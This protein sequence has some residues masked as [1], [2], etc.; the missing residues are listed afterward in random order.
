MSAGSLLIL[1]QENRPGTTIADLTRAGYESRTSRQGAFLRQ[2][3]KAESRARRTRKLLQNRLEMI[4][5]HDNLGNGMPNLG[6]RGSDMSTSSSESETSSDEECEEPEPN[7]RS[8]HRLSAAEVQDELKQYYDWPV[9]TLPRE[10]E[11]TKYARLRCEG[12]DRLRTVKEYE[13]ALGEEYGRLPRPLSSSIEI[14]SL[15]AK[16][17]FVLRALHEALQDKFV[18]FGNKFEVGH[19]GDALN[20]ADIRW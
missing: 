20:L 1:R 10:K 12:R 5:H 19:L 9:A 3:T 18:I 14:T 16:I 13:E 2:L 4:E 11:K 6:A 15:S 8:I 17:D 7:V